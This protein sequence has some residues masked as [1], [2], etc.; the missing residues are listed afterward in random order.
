MLCDTMY[1]QNGDLTNLLKSARKKVPQSTCLS[2][3]QSQFGQCPNRGCNIFDGASLQGTKWPMSISKGLIYSKEDKNDVR[4]GSKCV[5][6]FDCLSVCV[7]IFVVQCVVFLLQCNCCSVIFAVYLLQCNCCSVIVTFQT[8]RQRHK[9]TILCHR[10]N[11]TS[12]HFF[13]LL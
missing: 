7:I 4:F 11:V 1:C 5:V 13:S 10:Q 2:V 6:V 9:E 8:K 12:H 3:G